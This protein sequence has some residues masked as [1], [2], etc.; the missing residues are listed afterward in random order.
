[1]TITDIV[2]AVYFRTGT[3][4][5]SFPA[6]DML[7]FINIAYDRVVSLINHS[8]SKQQWDDGNETDLPSTTF[9]LVSGQKD[10]S[11]A[12]THHTIDRVEPLPNEGGATSWKLLTQIDRTDIDISLPA[13]AGANG[14][15]SEYDLVGTSIILYS[16]P[17]YTQ[18][19]SMRIYFT[20]GGKLFTSAEVT[21]GTKTPGFV[22]TFHD[23]IP[24]W[25]SYDYAIVNL[26]NIAAGLFA[27]IQRKEK[28]LVE[29]YGGRNRDR[30]PRFTVSTNGGGGFQSGRI[31]GGFGDSNE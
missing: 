25:V 1:M 29:F 13:Y 30:R 9:A 14:E 11:L 28:E 17:N 26:P 10:Y 5:S 4:S 22:S 7:I 31:N 15:P 19:A 2:N 21:T 16:A 27:E 12:T 23:L 24:L 6:A 3:N 8:D 18:A 20:R